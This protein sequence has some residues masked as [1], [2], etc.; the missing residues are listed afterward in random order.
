[1]GI[2]IFSRLECGRWTVE[3]G[4]RKRRTALLSCHR[5]L[6][7]SVSISAAFHT[8]HSTFDPVPRFILPYHRPPATVYR[9]VFILTFFLKR[10]LIGLGMWME[11]HFFFSIFLSDSVAGSFRIDRG[12]E[13]DLPRNRLLPA[14]AQGK[15]WPVRDTDRGCFPSF[16]SSCTGQTGP[17]RD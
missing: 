10:Y 6:L 13:K 15:L 9:P 11:F 14:F 8:P 7:F 5:P 2:S 3:D 4:R 12:G 16:E 1:M 17:E